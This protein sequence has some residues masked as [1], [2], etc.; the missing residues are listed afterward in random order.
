M[1]LLAVI[2]RAEMLKAAGMRDEVLPVAREI[3]ERD[4]DMAYHKDLWYRVIPETRAFEI[5]WL[6]WEDA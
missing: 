1:R 3:L 2:D 4:L 5:Y 6:S